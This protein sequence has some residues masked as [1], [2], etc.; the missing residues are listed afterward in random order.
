MFK[1]I[2]KDL[3]KDYV[4]K[5]VNEKKDIRQLVGT[6]GSHT[7]VIELRDDLLL[8]YNFN[9]LQELKQMTGRV[10]D[11]DESLTFFCGAFV[12]ARID[13]A[14]LSSITDDDL[15]YVKESVVI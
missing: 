4:V 2:F 1:V 13:G 11:K 9:K 3:D 15:K 5:E 7:E 14:N 6:D 10:F 12:V 8:F